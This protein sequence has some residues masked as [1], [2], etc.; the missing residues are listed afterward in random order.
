[1]FSEIINKFANKAPITLMV[2]ALLERLLDHASIDKW[3]DNISVNQYK[4]NILFSSVL[5]IMLQVVCRTR[6]SV[7]SA[8]INS[9]DVGATIVALYDKLKCTE[10]TTSR[11][12]VKYIALKA[13]AIINSMNAR[14]KPMLDN[15]RVKFLDGNCI[16]A[17]EHRINVLRNTN[18][19]A[20]PGKSLVVFDPQLELAIDVIPCEDGHAQE[21]SILR[22][23]VDAIMKNDLWVADRNFCVLWFLF[24]II[25]KSAFFVIRQHMGMPYKPLNELQFIG[26]TETGDIYEQDVLIVSGEG[27][28]EV[29]RRIVIKL[30]TKTR[31]GE[32]KIGIF[33]NLPKEDA[34][35]VTVS[36][37]Y[38]SR[39]GIETAF[40][41]LEAYF[42]SE[43]N[44]LAYPKSALFGFCVALVAFNIYS[45]VMAALRAAHPEIDI[46]EEVSEYYISEE[47]SSTH[48]GMLVAT[49]YADFEVFRQCSIEEFALILLYLASKV[50]LSKFKKK[51]RG[52]KKQ[53]LPRTK[54]KG[55]PHVSTARLL[56]PGTG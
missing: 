18:A 33:T 32:T 43:I 41:K 44:T 53:H 25:E 21:R 36:G 45:V 48:A 17:T 50:E 12:L 49:E 2:H 5:N 13:E 20:L 35:A 19:G 8:Y 54:F 4:R 29:I 34:D 37:I 31:N 1:M 52:P 55:Q 56:R 23:I 6:A 16:E 3:F 40:Q 38:R 22:K 9:S 39:W 46:K 24:K 11:E 42:E 27:K 14:N 26:T 7:H 47:I 10:I 30:Y 15:C 28:Q 51:K